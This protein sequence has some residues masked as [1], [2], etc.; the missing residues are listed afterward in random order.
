MERALFLDQFNAQH[1]SIKVTMETELDQWIAL[2]DVLVERCDVRLTYKLYRKPMHTNRYLHALLNHHHNQH[3]GVISTLI[4][5]AQRI[6]GEEKEEEQ[7]H[8]QVTVRS[9]GYGVPEIRPYN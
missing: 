7:E 1:P 5:R 4:E 6:C 9:N 8:L 2:L 3:R